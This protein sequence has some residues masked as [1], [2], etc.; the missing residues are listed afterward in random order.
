MRS[1]MD[2]HSQ[3]HS[4][5]P[6]IGAA[7]DD[8]PD[9]MRADELD[10]ADGFSQPEPFL[11]PPEDRRGG[12]SPWL[13]LLL[14]LV[15]GAVAVWLYQ[16]H[17][18]TPVTTVETAPAAVTETPPPS[19]E[20]PPRPRLKLPPLDASDPVIRQLVAT[21]SAQPK[22]VEWLANDRL[23][24]RFV[25]VVDN[26]ARGESPKPHLRF[27]DPGRGFVAEESSAGPAIDPRS[28]RRFDLLAN[29]V[30]S[31]D[32]AGTLRAFEDLEPLLAEAYSDLGYPDGDLRQ[33]LAA[34][35]RQLLATPVPTAAP[36][37]E[38][39]IRSYHYREARYQRLNQAQKHLLRM[40]P[41]NMRQVQAKL[42][43][44]AIAL[45]LDI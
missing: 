27:L 6:D 7:L 43:Q 19:S 5:L 4:D 10:A 12:L 2:K 15:L 36:L 17:T 34:A 30:A 38:E 45:G 24:R 31:L 42:R 8:G 35:I 37:L 13:I 44:L 40:G 9:L 20:P 14:L 16:R 23:A 21:L 29:A 25:A 39:R 11:P 28:Y 26:L 1:D 32:T 33:T 18:A 22:L 41:E 3:P